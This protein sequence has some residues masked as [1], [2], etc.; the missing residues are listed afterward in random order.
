LVP[1]EP[2]DVPSLDRGPADAVVRAG[3][4]VAARMLLISARTDPT[5]DTAEPPLPPPDPPAPALFPDAP[6]G[7][8]H[9]YYA[10]M[11]WLASLTTD[12]ERLAGGAGAAATPTPTPR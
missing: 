11:A 2:V 4:R 7:T 3:D 6:P 12:L 8:P 10:T 1:P 9:A 5:G